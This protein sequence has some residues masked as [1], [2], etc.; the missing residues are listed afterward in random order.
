MPF[1]RVGFGEIVLI[2]LVLLIVFGPRRLPELGG[3]LGK[4]IREFKRSVSDMK[5]GLSGEEEA[6]PNQFS[7][8]MQQVPGAV[9]ANEPLAAAEKE[10]EAVERG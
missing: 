10:K 5:A 2:L 8:P 7:K 1:P 9:A 6:S 3:A 4:G